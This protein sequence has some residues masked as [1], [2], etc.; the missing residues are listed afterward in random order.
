MASVVSAQ[1]KY[2]LLVYVVW[3]YVWATVWP[4]GF[5]VCDDRLWVDGGY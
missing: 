1:P 2:I 5:L 3:I 4:S